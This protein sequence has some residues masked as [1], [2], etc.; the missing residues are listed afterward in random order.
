MSRQGSGTKIGASPLATRL[1][2]I[3]FGL[4]L[5]AAVAAISEPFSG[6]W[7]KSLFWSLFTFAPLLINRRFRSAAFGS[8]GEVT[9]R[10]P[11]GR[12]SGAAPAPVAAPAAPEPP[13][14]LD[15]SGLDVP[16]TVAGV[17]AAL[18]EVMPL[19]CELRLD[20][21]ELVI[22]NS[23]AT[24]RR[25]L[26]VAPSRPAPDAAEQLEQLEQQILVLLSTVAG[27]AAANG[28][29]RWPV[30]EL[31]ALA[32]TVVTERSVF[33]WY[34]HGGRPLLLL[35]EVPLAVLPGRPAAARRG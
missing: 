2:V 35:D 22:W 28:I 3:G 10:V 19:D 30:A 31:G 9:V 33:A 32:R 20:P 26:V 24:V 6:G 11:S 14:Q 17:A 23:V 16:A 25:S 7:G 8:L 27:F 5:Y 21:S 13:P 29:G 4:A 15:W 1:F 18:R 34:E 12:R